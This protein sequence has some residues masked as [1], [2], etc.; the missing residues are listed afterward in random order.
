MNAA[1]AIV[2]G[3]PV[4][5]ML[6]LFLDYYGVKSVLFN[7]AETTR[8]HPKGG[9]EG[10]RAMEHFRRLG[11]SHKI[12]ELGLP[13]DHPTDVAYFTRFGS[14]ELA[15][16]P[17]PSRNQVLRQIAESP[18]TAQTPEP[19]HRANQMEVDR[20]LFS[21]A[22]TRPNIE[23]RFG[24]HVTH[25]EQKKDGVDV[26]AENSANGQSR[27][28]R[29]E[30]LVGC[31][32]GR[33]IVRQLL[34]IKYGGAASIEQKYLGGRMF[35]TYVRSPALFHDFLSR[36]PAWMYWAV[37][38]EIRSTIFSLNGYDEFLLRTPASSPDQPPEDATVADIIRR[39]AG[40]D[41]RMEIIAH[42]PWTAG[43]ALVAERFVEGRV[44][45]A[46]DAAHLFT[47]TGGFGMNTGIDG[48]SNLAWKLAAVLQGW[49]GSGL[50]ASY[51]A[52]RMPIGHRNT[53]EARKLTTNI[54]ATHVDACIEDETPAGEAARRAAGKML[55]GFSEQFASIGIQLGA[56]YD[57]S[58]LIV[59]DGKAPDDHA[60]RY[61]PTSVPGGRA[62]HV[63]LDNG[64]VYGSSLYDQFSAGF[65]LLRLGPKAPDAPELVAAAARR[66]VPFKVLEVPDPEARGLYQCDL[67]LV[68]PDQYV[69]WRGNK[70]PVDADALFS[71]VVGGDP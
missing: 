70:E 35:S 52:E 21:H 46:G 2:G 11:F 4:G 44:F 34:G 67:V 59:E 48:V 8:W 10:T 45:L 49:G 38:P 32:G 36:R 33:S 25:F 6:A 60:E 16:L 20:F 12:R 50:L 29:T 5:L 19:V 65:T 41:V 26:T 58:A 54:G 68:R 43:M 57:G 64:R 39:C 28:W 55:A 27:T 1:V 40:A 61:T 37:N 24:W 23:S 13:P 7:T 51:E 30:Y 22:K 66:H 62:P 56:R 3:G 53:R 9:T 15:R 14:H 71:Q 69:A 17:M 47:P 18:K 31:D 42:S 63:W